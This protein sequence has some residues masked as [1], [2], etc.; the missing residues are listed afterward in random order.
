MCSNG[1]QYTLTAH[2]IKSSKPRISNKNY[3]VGPRIGTDADDQQ[4]IN[5][6]GLY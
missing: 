5:L 3:A 2:T 6:N 1:E 4:V